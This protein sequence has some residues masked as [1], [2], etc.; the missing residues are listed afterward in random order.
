MDVLTEDVRD[1][2]LMEL[3]Y[4][5]D[6]V[7]CGESLNDV[8]DKYKRWKNAVEGKGLRVSVDKTK[9]MQLSFGKKSSVSKVDPCGVCGERVG[10][11]S[12]QCTKC[13]RWIHRRCSDVPR[14]VSLLSCRDIFVCRTCLCHNC[15]VVVR[16]EFKRGEDIL[17]EVEKFS[18]LGDMINCFG[19]AS[20]AVSARIGSAWKKFREL[21]RVLVGKQGL[22]LM[23]RGKIYQC[24]V[25]PV[26]LYC[27]ETWEL[28]VVDEI[29]LCGVERCM[30]RMMC[31]VRLV[32]RVS[33]DV[34]RDKVGVVVT[35]KDSIIQRR[36]RWYGHVIR[37]DISSEIREVMEHE[38]PG[39]RKKGRP[40]KSWE[41]C[42]KKDLERY[43]LR[44]EDAYDR[45]K[46]REHI[47]AKI[48][49]PGQPG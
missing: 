20:E 45:V 4:A 1:G 30:I 48:A 11:S 10:C 26:L 33:T 44:R 15:S 39:K 6:L 27:C 17:E 41:E 42:V 29:R 21:S 9:G 23:Q 14:Q 18:Y 46:W 2:S 36:L 5:D 22:S 32:D 37:R 40:R 7:L 8:M 38:I 31:G 13:Q 3:L 28:T 49:N 43:G 34:L 19:G 25:R 47:K 24:C 12:I 35:I 16:L